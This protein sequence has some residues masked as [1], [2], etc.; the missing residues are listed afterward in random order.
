MARQYVL[1]DQT[2]SSN[3]DGSFIAHQ[4]SVAAYADR[5]VDNP[6]GPWGCEGGKTD[7]IA[8]LTKKRT[9]G[10]RIVTCFDI[11]SIATQAD[12][13]GLSWRFYT[14]GLYSDGGLWSSFQAESKIYDG[15]DWTTDV[16]NP[17]AQFLNRS[18]RRPAGKRDVDHA[19]V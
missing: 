1:G 10:S 15:P 19:D 17:P 14:G 18:R 4:Y 3:I 6:A 9:Y 11:P 5:A 13:A 12:R 7:T 16:I 2:F 8:Q